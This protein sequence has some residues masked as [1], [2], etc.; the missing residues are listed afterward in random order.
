MSKSITFFKTV[1]V[2]EPFISRN[3]IKNISF[4]LEL[5]FISILLLGVL[6]VL[7]LFSPYIYTLYNKNK[8]KDVSLLVTNSEL[9]TAIYKFHQDYDFYNLKFAVL[10]LI[11]FKNN[12]KTLDIVKINSLI[13]KELAESISLLDNQ[14]YGY[15]NNFQK[16]EVVNLLK[17]LNYIS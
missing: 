5:G 14:I 1:T 16:T 8:N 7:F 12:L 3:T 11:M 10:R 4:D 9:E 6:F 2:Q 15:K 13:P 17:K